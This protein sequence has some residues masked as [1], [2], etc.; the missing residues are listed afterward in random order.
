MLSTIDQMT[1]AFHQGNIDG[2]MATYEPGAVVISE[3]GRPLSGTAALR[4]MFA[5]FVA[6]KAR[7]TFSGH[8]VV[9]SDDIALHLTPWRMAGVAPDE[10]PI[11]AN[12]L[13]VAV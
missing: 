10:T 3:P 5:G 4:A 12:G 7:F 2:I 13:S 9:Q 11:T 8:E 6:A 1:K